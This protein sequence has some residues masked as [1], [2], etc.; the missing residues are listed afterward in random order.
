MVGLG[1]LPGGGFESAALGDCAEGAVVVGYGSTASGDEA[2]RWTAGGGMQRLWD[3]LLA[4]GVNAAADGWTRLEGAA[5]INADGNTIVGS[6]FRNGN[7]EAFVAVIPT[8]VPNPAADFNH[9]GDVDRDDLFKWE[10]DFGLSA[11]SDADNDNDSDGA[12]FLAWHGN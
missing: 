6:G 2:F 5:G 1:D 9:D 11:G 8:V 4:Q 12:D 3:L 10:G 7:T